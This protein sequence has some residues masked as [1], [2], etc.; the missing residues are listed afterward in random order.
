MPVH[1]GT[2]DVDFPHFLIHR[3]RYSIVGNILS[4][5]VGTI[6]QVD[7]AR[8]IRAAK[9]NGADAILVAP[10]GTITILIEAPPLAPSDEDVFQK[11][12]REH[13]SAKASRRRD[14]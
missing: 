13:E 3:C 5:R 10:D 7:V 6:L 12:E 8:A 2:L 9:P 11:W 14:R 4:R 1:G